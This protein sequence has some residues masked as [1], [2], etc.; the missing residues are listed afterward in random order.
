MS[1]IRN[2]SGAVLPE[3]DQGKSELEV[4]DRG[5]QAILMYILLHPT[6]ATLAVSLSQQTQYLQGILRAVRISG[7]PC[8]DSHLECICIFSSTIFDSC[9]PLVTVRVVKSHGRDPVCSVNAIRWPF[10]GLPRAGL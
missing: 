9:R 5:I 8:C 2:S 6:R 1:L 3:D 4:L 7:P 10:L